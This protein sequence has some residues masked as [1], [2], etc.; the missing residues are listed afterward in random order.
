MFFT[1]LTEHQTPIYF[2]LL[3]F[4]LSQFALLAPPLNAGEARAGPSAFSLAMSN[5]LSISSG[6]LVLIP[7][8]C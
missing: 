8:M 1:C 2:L 3:H 4:V 5:S 7:P 6:H